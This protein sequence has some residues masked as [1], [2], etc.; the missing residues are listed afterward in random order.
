MLCYISYIVVG[1]TSCTFIICLIMYSLQLHIYVIVL[2]LLV[3]LRSFA[4]GFERSVLI[5]VLTACLPVYA[6]PGV[7]CVPRT[8]GG[9]CIWQTA[10]CFE[11]NV[12]RLNLHSHDISWL[13]Q[14][15]K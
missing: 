4:F 8:V 9:L 12:H 11:H 3:A 1:I 5:A 13:A 15:I 10:Q 6:D 2:L 7:S 14:T